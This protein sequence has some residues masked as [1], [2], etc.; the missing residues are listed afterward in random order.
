MDQIGKNLEDARINAA[1]SM[2]AAAD[3]VGISRGSLSRYE[4]N[5]RHPDAE[6]LAKM[7]QAYKCD[8]NALMNGKPQAKFVVK[9]PIAGFVITNELFEI[10]EGPYREFLPIHAEEDVVAVEVHGNALAGRA[11]NGEY[12]LIRK[13]PPSKEKLFV[14]AHS[15]DLAIQKSAGEIVGVYRRP[16]GA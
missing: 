13:A 1:L 12:L 9:V 5:W 3:A 8:V 4:N 16:R 7:A 11:Y 2:E 15:E 10:N 14:S 6:V